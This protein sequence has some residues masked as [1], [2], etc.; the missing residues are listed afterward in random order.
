MTLTRKVLLLNASYEPLGIVSLHR[1]IRLVWKGLA[2]V[3]ERE[4]DS[5][6]LAVDLCDASRLDCEVEAEYVNARNAMPPLDGK[7]RNVRELLKCPVNWYLV[8]TRRLA[9]ANLL[10]EFWGEVV[11][12]YQVDSEGEYV[13]DDLFIEGFE[14]D[15]E[16]DEE[17]LDWQIGNIEYW[18]KEARQDYIERTRRF[19]D[20]IMAD[21]KKYPKHFPSAKWTKAQVQQ[22][23]LSGD[24][25]F[26]SDVSIDDLMDLVWD[27]LPCSCSRECAEDCNGPWRQLLKLDHIKLYVEAEEP[28][29]ASKGEETQ[30]VCL[31]FDCNTPEVHAYPVTRDEIQSQIIRVESRGGTWKDLFLG[32]D[33]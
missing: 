29:G 7:R 14:L 16:E 17:Y 4:P 2:E 12:E 31:D 21:R 15:A 9:L 30:F 25:V 28:M 5:G 22:Q 26:Y 32:R 6:G 33:L 8:I 13:W 3:V 10:D 11:R 27:S 18:I 1:A 20:L 24:S 19:K 23:S